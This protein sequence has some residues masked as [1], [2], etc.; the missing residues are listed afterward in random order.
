MQ[1]LHLR[2]AGAKQSVL[3][4]VSR[5]LQSR[6]DFRG[7]QYT[8]PALWSSVL[9]D[10]GSGWELPKRQAPKKPKRREPEQFWRTQDALSEVMLELSITGY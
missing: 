4:N 10:R 8:I 6:I 1:L 3:S 2:P 9:G 7:E 5:K